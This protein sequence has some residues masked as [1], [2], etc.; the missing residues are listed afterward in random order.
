MHVV[1]C[2]I[3]HDNIL[4]S[5]C[6]RR[7]FRLPNAHA[8]ALTAPATGAPDPGVTGRGVEGSLSI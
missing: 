3:V 8:L 6:L 1:V 7:P 5:W 4:F 2:M